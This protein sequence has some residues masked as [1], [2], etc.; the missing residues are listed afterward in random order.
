M[1]AKTEMTNVEKLAVELTRFATFRGRDYGLS[2][3]ELVE[4][5]EFVAKHGREEMKRSEREKNASKN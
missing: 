1:P 4:A 5:M 2:L 3:K